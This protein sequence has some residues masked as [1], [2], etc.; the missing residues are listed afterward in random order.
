MFEL[1]TFYCI[2][3]I[4]ENWLQVN[5]IVILLMILLSRDC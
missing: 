2:I 4:N 5:L 1:F 3:Y